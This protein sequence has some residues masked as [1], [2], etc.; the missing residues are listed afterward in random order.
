MEF[1]FDE[2]DAW[3]LFCQNYFSVRMSGIWEKAV[4][5]FNLQFISLRHDDKS[6]QVASDLTWEQMETLVSQYGIGVSDAMI[7]NLFLSS[8]FPAV[9]TADSD[10]VY[11]LEKLKPSGKIAIIPNSLLNLSTR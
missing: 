3:Q 2:H 5:L 7:L 10:L 8:T 11:V 1:K 6:T 9:F 4:D